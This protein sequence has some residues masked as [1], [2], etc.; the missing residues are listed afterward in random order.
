MAESPT[1][2]EAHIRPEWLADGDSFTVEVSGATSF[3]GQTA[4]VQ[5]F[6]IDAL[7]TGWHSSFSITIGADGTG[8]VSDPIVLDFGGRHTSIYVHALQR[9]REV[10]TFPEVFM[11][12]V[13]S[14]SPGTNLG[15]VLDQHLQL[16]A[17]QNSYYGVP[18][19][20]PASPGA[21]QFRGVA[22][23]EG[24]LTTKR[25][26]VPGATI[27]PIDQRPDAPDRRVIVNKVLEGLDWPSRVPEEFWRNGVASA[28]PITIVVCPQV[29][30]GD[31]DGAG[32]LIANVEEDLISMLALNRGATARP[33]ATMIEERKPDGG[34]GYRLYLPIP[35]Y[36]GNLVGGFIA[37]ED[38]RSLLT[39]YLSVRSDP[40]LKLCCDLYAE[41]L[42][43]RSP[44]ARFLRLWSLLEL[45]SGARLTAGAV[46]TL[47]DGTAW[48]GGS[49][50]TAYA[51]PRV[52]SYISAHFAAG[53]FDEA[54][55]VAPA[56]NLYEAVRV[57]YA[58]RNA[59]GHYGRFLLTDPTQS[60]Q[61]W[62]P[63][64]ARSSSNEDAWLRSLRSVV[65]MVLHRE[66]HE[67]APALS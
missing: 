53:P 19:G 15:E 60:A 50:T 51:A 23:L 41:A 64:A 5:V 10:Y 28:H 27:I 4:Q 21:T 1:G 66:L 56:S 65:E 17:S 8:Q 47:L 3:S 48:P 61:K 16:V 54:S 14:L 30:A 39:E 57:W 43:D 29:W 46:V 63:W 25:L 2:I 36:G 62:H 34:I 13:N 35:T 44:D 42:A 38:Q 45:L 26:R 40:L 22:V 55:T 59:T 20:D 9:E 24:I 49:N 12:I 6:S 7:D 31:M 37:G 52:Y 32:R 33:V 67:H 58:R 11:S 18:V